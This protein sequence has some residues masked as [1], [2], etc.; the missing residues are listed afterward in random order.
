VGSATSNR[1]RGENQ[2]SGR[3]VTKSFVDVPA[4]SGEAAQPQDLTET[5]AENL[6]RLRVRAGLSLEKLAHS[7]GVSRAMLGQIER[8]QSVPT[9]NVLWK[10]ARALSVPFSRLFE[11]H[12]VR[13]T[14]F[15]PASQAKR[16]TS[17][18]GNFV[19]RALF[20]FGAA[21][22]VECYELRLAALSA[23]NA[24]A[25]APGTVEHL[26][27]NQGTLVLE[28]GGGRHRLEVGDALIFEADSSHTY[29][30]PGDI[31]TVLHLVMS[32]AGGDE[33]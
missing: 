8:A 20:S 14:R 3:R 29:K 10:V 5:V 12:T 31:E 30:N 15:I 32:Y 24:D 4:L 28:V 11:N 22:R 6:H 26:F 23:K 7:S 1:R 27:L 16:L 25:H 2:N 19:S 18:N 13:Q 17:N 33:S 21:K 9:I